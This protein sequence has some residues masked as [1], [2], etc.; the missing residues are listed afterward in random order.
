MKICIPITSRAAYGRLRPVLREFHERAELQIIVACSATVDRYGNVAEEIRDE[1]PVAITCQSAVYG[2]EPGAMA[3]SMGLLVTE[4]VPA[5][6]HLA[7]D[8]VLAHAD[9]YETLAV[10]TAASY[11]N[12]PLAH[13]QGG[14]VT[15][16]IDNKVRDATSMLADIHFPATARAAER[17]SSMGLANID[18]VGCPSIDTLVQEDLPELWDIPVNEYGYG[19]L[20]DLEEPF[21]L[22][23]LHADT[24]D[25]DSSL[26]TLEASMEALS[27]YQVIWLL[28]N[29]DAYGQE[30]TKR[31][32]QRLADSGRFR[33]VKHLPQMEF[34]A[35]MDHCTVMVGNSSSM[36]R[37]GSYMGV[38]G[39][40]VG[41]RQQHREVCANVQQVKGHTP[42]ATE[43]KTAILRQINH[44]NYD[45][46]Y[47]YGD[48]N[49]APRIAT[50]ILTV[51]RDM[52]R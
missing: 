27:G 47:I 5:F 1:F 14:E 7:P 35:L 25:H 12:I 52:R 19:F 36:I 17:L 42:L 6:A 34:Y 43:I 18:C 13:T 2:D 44:S 3:V 51:L 20:I 22:A 50:R 40:L 28:P 21:I 30:M 49:A 9:R 23:C 48:G 33:A 24:T 31:I 41:A 15:G 16:S 26:A 45:Q 46:Q 29:I 8:L 10:A 11:M 39:V 38:P 4:L 37:E 32:N